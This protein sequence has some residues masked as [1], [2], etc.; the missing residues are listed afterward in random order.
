[1]QHLLEFMM[2]SIVLEQ[3]SDIDAAL[4]CMDRALILDPVFLPALMRRGTLLQNAQRHEEAIDC[5]DL[6]MRYSPQLEQARQLRD[7]A[8]D[9]ALAHAEQQLADTPDSMDARAHRAA[10]LTRMERHAAAL[11]DY[12]A[13]LA[14][15]PENAEARNRRANLLLAMDQPERAL[16]EYDAVLAAL[17]DQVAVMFNRA[18]T[19]QKMQRLDEAVAAYQQVLALR[20]HFAEAKL[21]QAQCLLLAGDYA[22]GWQQH[23]ARWQT[24][25]LEAHHLPS[26]APQWLGD[27][28]LAGQRLLLWAEQ[29]LGDTLQ[30]V[31]Y[32]ALAAQL[33]QQANPP[34]QVLLRVPAPLLTL[35]QP[36]QAEYGIV[37]S[38]NAAVLPEHDLHCSLMSLPLALA[39]TQNTIPAS[40]A[41]LHADT[42]LSAA[43]RERLPIENSNS[44]RIGLAWAGRQYGPVNRSRDL[45]LERWNA[46]VPAAMQAM[47]GS[48][49]SS[50]PIF[51]SLQKDIP[52]S[53]LALAETMPDFALLGSDLQ[54]FA[55]TAALI[56]NLDLVISVDTAV[57]HLAA[58]LGKPVWLL[59]RHSSEWRWLLERNDSPWY[60]SMRIFRQATPGD[61]DSVL[62][63][64][65]RE[66]YTLRR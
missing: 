48:G 51:Y 34:G 40:S 2:Q 8:L 46:I 66:L 53:E 61:W 11:A 35:L 65:A 33:A 14:A 24:A 63:E 6:A 43:W 59:L 49:N 44:L 19:L 60:P 26:K 7:A 4:A 29:G 18:N 20:P 22:R 36:L 3:Q 13:V 58:A 16:A 17:P 27:Y 21:E 37:V 30:F 64:V 42:M 28:P 1:M 15:L 47:T 62:R 56:D 10:I 39:D 38:A 23:E 41:Y 31:R 52:A 57:A 25:Q 50:L 12:D 55:D 5:F 54:D 9:L 32:V 45:P